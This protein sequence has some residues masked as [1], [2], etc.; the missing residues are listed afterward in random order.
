MHLRLNW[1]ESLMQWILF[2]IKCLEV[3]WTFKTRWLLALNKNF[4]FSFACL[5]FNQNTMVDKLSTYMQFNWRWINGGALFRIFVKV[6]LVTVNW[7]PSWITDLFLR[8][9]LGTI[10]IFLKTGWSIWSF[11]L[12][13]IFSFWFWWRM[14]LMRPFLFIW[15]VK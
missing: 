3:P 1:Y 13:Q 8:V 11:S 4:F 9:L 15:Q 10:R 2:S 6:W 14:V 5:S 7:V 12:F